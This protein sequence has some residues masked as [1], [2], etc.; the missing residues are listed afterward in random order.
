MQEQIGFGSSNGHQESDGGSN[1]GSGSGGSERVFA[2]TKRMAVAAETQ[3]AGNIS[4]YSKAD[5]VKGLIGMVFICCLEI[6]SSV[7]A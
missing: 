6:Q 5:N 7:F 3:D 2:A 4:T 1:S